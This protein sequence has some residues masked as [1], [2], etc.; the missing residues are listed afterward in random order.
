MKVGIL[1]FHCAHNYGAVL[2][3]YALQEKLKTLGHDVKIIDYRPSYLLKP[4]AVFNSSRYISQNP[5]I[6]GKRVL[7]EI[8]KLKRRISRAT[9]FNHFIRNNLNLTNYSVDNS[10]SVPCIYDVYILGSDQ[11][12]NSKI[13]QGFDNI[14]FGNFETSPHSKIIT[15]AASMGDIIISPQISEFIQVNFENF[16]AISVRESSMKI[17]LQPLISNKIYNV[18]DPIFLVGSKFWDSIGEV[19]PIKEKYV[20]VYQV[21]KNNEALKIAQQV[22]DRINAKVIQITASID[23]WKYNKTILQCESP[24]AFIGWIK[25]ASF[26][27]TTSFHGAAFSVTFNKSFFVHNNKTRGSSRIESL[28]KIFKLE[29]R[30]VENPAEI[31]QEKITA[32]INWEITNQILIEQKEK[33]LDFLITNLQ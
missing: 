4:Y 14:F 6:T 12:W 9:K 30:L 20:V 23:T 16:D 10:K 1:T 19:P 27:V 11:I 3:A 17:S 22:A 18:L 24:A 25:H 28:L 21:I 5:F 31:T 15:Y 2:Q 33:S 7:I 8:L 13:T 32:K 29:D 26:V